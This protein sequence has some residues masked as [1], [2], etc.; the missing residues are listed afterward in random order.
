M[1]Y[2]IAKQVKKSFNPQFQKTYRVE[3]AFKTK[4]LKEKMIP[5]LRYL[6]FCLAVNLLRKA[7]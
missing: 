2:S 3:V 7:R 1:E 4:L 6:C 5:N